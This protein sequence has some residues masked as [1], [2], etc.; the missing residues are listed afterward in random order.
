MNKNIAVP[1]TLG[2][3]LEFYIK[4]LD[5]RSFILFLLFYT[6]FHFMKLADYVKDLKKI[7]IGDKIV[8]WLKKLA[9]TDTENTVHTFQLFVHLLDNRLCS[10]TAL[11]LLI[12][13]THSFFLSPPN[14]PL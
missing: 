11:I 5:I 10:K 12:L 2:L 3:C 6:V 1:H 14:I 9:G 13:I 8:P 4:S 7:E